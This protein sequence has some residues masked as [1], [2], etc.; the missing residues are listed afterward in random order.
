M[1]KRCAEFE[2]AIPRFPLKLAIHIK[3]QAGESDRKSENLSAAGASFHR[4]V[5]M[6]MGSTVDFNI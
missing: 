4:D 5:E 3:S 6:S 1:R 2:G